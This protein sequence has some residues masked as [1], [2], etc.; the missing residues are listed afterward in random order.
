MKNEGFQVRSLGNV[1]LGEDERRIFQTHGGKRIVDD[2]SQ[3]GW[4]GL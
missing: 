4:N 2:L 1:R 3:T